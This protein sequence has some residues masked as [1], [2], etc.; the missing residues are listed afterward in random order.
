LIAAGG[1][2]RSTSVIP[3]V[4]AASSV[5]TIAFI[6]HLPVSLSPVAALHR[7]RRSA[8][9]EATALHRAE[10]TECKRDTRNDDGD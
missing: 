3:A 9:G 4:P 5:T 2:G 1:S 6:G 8:H 10:R 7:R